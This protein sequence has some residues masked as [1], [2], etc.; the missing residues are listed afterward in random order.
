M[1]E[2]GLAISIIDAFKETYLI[3]KFIY[4]SVQ[5]AIDEKSERQEIEDNLHF[6]LLKLQSFGRWFQKTR[7]SITDDSE[8]DKVVPFLG[9]R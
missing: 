6:E 4:K 1:A 7:G 5:S 2:L 9:C 8:I 3:G